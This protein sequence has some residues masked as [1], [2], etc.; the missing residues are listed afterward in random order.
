MIGKL[1]WATLT[2]CYAKAHFKALKTLDIMGSERAEDN[3]QEKVVYTAAAKGDLAQWLSKADFNN[4]KNIRPTSLSMSFFT[5]ASLTGCGPQFTFHDNV[6]NV[7][8]LTITEYRNKT[9]RK[10][11]TENPHSEVCKNPNI[12]DI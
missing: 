4:D 3:L 9:V 8:H 1:N 11:S 10:P 6:D 2:V 7:D 5:D 12:L